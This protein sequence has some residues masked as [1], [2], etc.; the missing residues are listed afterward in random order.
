[1][2]VKGTW[3][4]LPPILAVLFTYWA[5]DR[6]FQALILKEYHE[7]IAIGLM[8]VA[9]LLFLIRALT[10]QLE[11]DCIL[12]VVSVNFLCREIHFTGTD[13]AV[14]IISALVLIWVL[15]RKKHIWV[16]IES[17][18]LFK[19]SLCGTA[20]TYFF[21]VLIARRVFSVDN[22]SILPNEEF[23]YDRLEEVMENMAHLYLIFTAVVAFF[24][25]SSKGRKK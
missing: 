14:V 6:G 4:F 24:S 21:S 8:S 22:F 18:G 23:M 25:L 3:C 11:I 10:H 16:S 7:P 9:V 20:F 12:L 19:I 1:M 13:T 17:A 5:E 15:I 2:A